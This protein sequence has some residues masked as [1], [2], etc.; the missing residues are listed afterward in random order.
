MLRFCKTP[1]H[2]LPKAGTMHSLSCTTANLCQKVDNSDQISSK[3]KLLKKAPTVDS[4]QI[5][6]KHEGKTRKGKERG[7]GRMDR[8][9]GGWVNWQ[10]DGEGRKRGRVRMND[11]YAQAERCRTQLMRYRMRITAK[12][13]FAMSK[14]AQG[15]RNKRNVRV[16][17]GSSELG[18]ETASNRI[19]SVPPRAQ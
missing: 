7:M 10:T 18:N 14:K 3:S 15:W 17:D 16:K 12:T 1:V 8:W 19:S 4:K 13:K 2:D 5:R 9:T 11:N 6:S